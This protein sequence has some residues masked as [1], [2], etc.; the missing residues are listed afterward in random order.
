MLLFIRTLIIPNQ[1][2]S[3]FES[4]VDPDQKLADQDLHSFQLCLYMHALY[5][6]I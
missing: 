1:D 6:A 4:S 5:I 2:I 3:C